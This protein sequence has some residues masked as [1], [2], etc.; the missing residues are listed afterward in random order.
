MRPLTLI[1]LAAGAYAFWSMRQSRI[2]RKH[3]DDIVDTAVE[4]S[5]PASDPPAWTTGRD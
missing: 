3:E 4:D 1:A 5:F 2:E